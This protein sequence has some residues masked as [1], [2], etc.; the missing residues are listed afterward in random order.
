M[1][2]ASIIK[3]AHMKR[4]FLYF[5]IIILF[6]TNAGWCICDRGRIE[7]GANGKCYCRS[8]PSLYF[9]HAQAWCDALNS[10]GIT[11]STIHSVCD[12]DANDQWQEGSTDCPNFRTR[13]QI[14]N[15]TG[16]SIATGTHRVSTMTANHE[17]YILKV[18]SNK[19][20]VLT[21]AYDGKYD[22]YCDVPQSVCD[23]IRASW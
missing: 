22:V 10:E 19:V 17:G 8:N 6:G 1:E 18:E 16:G 7:F 12:Y 13:S 4:I 14:H 20:S 9:L 3:G 23:E 2:H 5:L 15:A 11:R 21:A